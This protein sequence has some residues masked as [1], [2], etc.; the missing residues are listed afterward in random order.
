MPH[1]KAMFRLSL[2]L[3]FSLMSLLCLVFKSLGEKM[4]ENTKIVGVCPL[5]VLVC[6]V[7]GLRPGVCP[8]PTQYVFVHK[9]LCCL[10]PS[11]LGVCPVLTQYVSVH[12][13]GCLFWPIWL[14]VCPVPTQYVSVHKLPCSLTLR[15]SY[16]TCW[17]SNFWFP[18]SLLPILALCE[19]S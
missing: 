15:V 4:L 3:L 10:W 9:F 5:A 12:K 7:L 19:E 13:L 18:P 16:V 1:W 8:V 17:W 14:G 2:A 6:V 11:R